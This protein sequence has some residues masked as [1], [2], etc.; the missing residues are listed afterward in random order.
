MNGEM[1]SGANHILEEIKRKPVE[2]KRDE[3]I[4]ENVNVL[5]DESHRTLQ[6]Q[7]KIPAPGESIPVEPHKVYVKQLETLNV[8]VLNEAIDLALRG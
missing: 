1:G 5:H 4:P 2:V 8:N 7:N 3:S 6:L